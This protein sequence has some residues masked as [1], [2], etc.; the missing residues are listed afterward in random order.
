MNNEG[1]AVFT[2]RMRIF[3]LLF[4]FKNWVRESSSKMEKNW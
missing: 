1:H 4:S 3:E 2:P